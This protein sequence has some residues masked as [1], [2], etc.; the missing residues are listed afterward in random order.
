MQTKDNEF[1]KY[2]ISFAFPRCFPI[3][4]FI[5]SVCFSLKSFFFASQMPRRNPKSFPAIHFKLFPSPSHFLHHLK[6]GHK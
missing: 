4:N 3:D 1:L 5:D 2:F 6:S